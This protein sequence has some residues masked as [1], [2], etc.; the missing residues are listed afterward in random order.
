MKYIILGIP[1]TSHRKFRLNS[2]LQYFFTDNWS[3]FQ[4]YRYNNGHH[5]AHVTGIL[6]DSGR[7]YRFV[8]KL[9]ARETCYQPVQSNGVLVLANPP[10]TNNIN[11]THDNT[12]T[13]EKVTFCI[14]H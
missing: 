4:D 3:M 1:L 9:C 2:L 12:S 8:V 11:V 6:L 7:L 13:V 14:I 5:Q 10:V